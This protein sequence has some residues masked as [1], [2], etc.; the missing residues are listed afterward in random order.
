[1][2][3]FLPLL[4]IGCGLPDTVT[5][6]PNERAAIEIVAAHFASQGL[7]LDT[8]AVDVTWYGG[9]CLLDWKADVDHFTIRKACVHGLA[10]GC[11]LQVILPE[12]VNALERSS[13]AHEM[14]HCQGWQWDGDLDINHSREGWR[15]LVPEARGMLRG[16]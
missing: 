10:L 1:M 13:L 16:L 7:P 2:R 11:N 3:R 14:L 15:T 8:S 6:P 9:Q 4:F 5:A 12:G